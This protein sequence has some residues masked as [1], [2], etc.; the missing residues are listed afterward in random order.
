MRIAIM[1]ANGHLGRKLIRALNED[2]PATDIVA[3]VRSEKAATQVR[4]VSRQARIEIV[5]YSSASDLAA[6]AKDC[7]KIV[8]LVG[9]I[10][11]SAHNT[12]KQAHEAPCK[13]LLDAGL[14]AS[15]IVYLGIHGSDIESTNACLR[16]RAKAESI[17]Q[18]GPIP[19]TII[20][21]PMV[22]GP[23][24]YASFALRRQAQA[25]VVFTFRSESLEQ[26]IY[27][28]DV[29]EAIMAVLRV[30][31][32]QQIIELA[33]AESL[34]RRELIKRAGRLFSNNPWVISLPIG[35]GLL[36]ARMFERLS[37]SPPVTGAMLGV[38]DHDDD[39]DVSPGASSLGIT[40]TGLDETLALVLKDSDH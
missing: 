26:P 36:M 32:E 35:M 33:G 21:V 17:L 18:A 2:Q 9:I 11:E 3:L 14:S 27:C 1:G 30:P 23:D 13:A 24:D 16:S 22:L 20:R 5:N 10:K 37:D 12:F 38:L 31:P 28:G 7:D 39:I 25:P 15:Q 40:L 4:K 6:A 19:T 34:P 8:H 29:I